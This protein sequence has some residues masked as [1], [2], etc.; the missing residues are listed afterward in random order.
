[1]TLKV[2]ILLFVAKIAYSQFEEGGCSVCGEGKKVGNGLGIFAYPEQP[3]VPCSLLE[4]AG[5]NGLIPLEQC[6]QLPPLVTVCECVPFIIYSAAPS[7]VPDSLATSSL[8]NTS[9]ATD[10][11]SMKRLSIFNFIMIVLAFLGFQS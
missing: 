4:S 6:S 3:E 8:S 1:M 5:V 2:F 10:N 9:G 7:N 11:I